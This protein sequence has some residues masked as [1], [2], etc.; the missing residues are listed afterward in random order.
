MITIL[1]YLKEMLPY[2]L[3]S[4]PIII[5][6]RFLWNRGKQVNWYREIVL[7]IFLVFLVGLASQT[8]IPK[9]HITDTIRLE[10]GRGRINLMPLKNLII[11]YIE[12]VHYK[13]F[14]YFL[15]NFVGN[16]I[17]FIPIGFCI[18][19]L[20]NRKGYQTIII[21]VLVSIMIELIQLPMNRGTDIDDVILNTMGIVIGLIIYK[22]SV[23]KCKVLLK[24]H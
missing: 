16:I 18:P 7:D 5:C 11:T 22:I 15:V 13:N 17:M 12:V 23:K 10:S 6:I 3:I 14:D 24:L 1:N 19:C 9:I 8:I 2:Q 21:G 4:I 20:W